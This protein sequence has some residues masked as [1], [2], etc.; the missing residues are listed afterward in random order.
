MGPRIFK[1]KI[2]ETEFVLSAIPLGGYVE[3]AGSAEMGQGDQAEAESNDENSFSK[4]PYYQKLLVMLGGILF[5][6]GFAYFALSL[7][8]LIGVP[9]SPLF[10]SH[11]T[12]KIVRIA[13]DSPADKKL[14]AGDKITTW[15]G[16][17]VETTSAL[18]EQISKEPGKEIAIGFIRDGKSMETPITLGKK[19]VK[20]SKDKTK[21]AGFLGVEFE[22]PRFGLMDSIKRGIKTTNNLIGQVVKAFKNM[23]SKREFS[24]LGGP[25]A[26]IAQTIQGAKDGFKTFILLLAFISVN[27]AILNIIPLPIFDG[28]Q[29]LNYTIEA[30]TRRPLPIKVREYIHIVTWVGVILLALYLSFKDV[31][32]MWW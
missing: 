21:E 1:K 20:I 18:M 28:G 19:E 5:N 3:I 26:V 11:A 14:I 32:K 12:Q 25:I 27:L 23:F 13:K 9:N 22:L 30:I 10:L 2:G 4:K 15:N 24:N 31:M 6:L 17:P 7:L 8:F 16:K 29:I